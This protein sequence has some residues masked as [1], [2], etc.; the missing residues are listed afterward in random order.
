MTRWIAPTL[1]TL[2]LLATACAANR[3]DQP[4][5]W[6]L[7]FYHTG[8]PDTEVFSLDRVVV[9]PLHWP[10]PPAGEATPSR[11]GAYR[12][13]VRGE[14]GGLVYAQGFSSIF[15]EWE[16]TAEA[17]SIHR[18]FHESLR[19]PAPFHE[20]SV[21]ACQQTALASASGCMTTA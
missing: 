20:C 1:L 3:Q 13:E 16:T 2:S 21:P 17:G 12:F 7:D 15:G 9:E 5:T 19:F 10:G 4:R 11:E 6:R 18:T 14:D 8:G